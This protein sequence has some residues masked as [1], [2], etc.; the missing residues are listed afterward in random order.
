MDFDAVPD[1]VESFETVYSVL[2]SRKQR[3]F[4]K[5]AQLQTTLKEN[6]TDL[7]AVEFV[8]E[9]YNFHN[10][11]LLNLL[12]TTG[13]VTDHDQRTMVSFN[14]VQSWFTNV[15]VDIIEQNLDKEL[16]YILV[17]VSKFDFYNHVRNKFNYII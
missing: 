14:K 15:F 3:V 12:F 13:E 7:I 2:E 6:L 1:S 11:Y 9:G 16:H 8:L 10:F 17:E 5:I 4:Q